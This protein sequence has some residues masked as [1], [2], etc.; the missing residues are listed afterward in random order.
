MKSSRGFTFIEVV[1]ALAVISILLP[2]VGIVFYN[3]IVTPPD[4]GVRLKL[5]NEIALLSSM[6]YQD[7]HLSNNFSEGTFPYYGNF[8]WTDYSV[9]PAQ[10]YLVSYYSTCPNA[11][12]TSCVNHIVRQVGYGNAST[13][14]IPT[15]TPTPTPV[16]TI[17][18]KIEAEAYDSMSGIATETTSDTGGGLNV[19]WT[20]PGD[21]MDYNV[22]VQTA[23]TYDITF[24]M[25]ADT[26]PPGKLELKEGGTLLCSVDTPVTG[27]WQTW[28]NVS[29]TAT[30][31]SGAKTLRISVVTAGWNL[32]WITFS[33]ATPTTQTYDYSA[34]YGV[35][36]W[37]WGRV[38]TN[39][40]WVTRPTNPD[41]F[42]EL[43]G[44]AAVEADTNMYSQLG[45]EDGNSWG[46]PNTSP[47]DYGVDS[48]LYTIQVNQ[49][50]S[51][52]TNLSVKWIGYG[53]NSTDSTKLKIW[54]CSG[55]GSWNTLLNV[56]GSGS[57][58]ITTHFFPNISS[59]LNYI[60]ATT[61]SV[62]LLASSEAVTPPAINYSDLTVYTDYIALTVIATGTAPTPTP[63]ATPK[64]SEVKTETLSTGTWTAPDGVT[65]IDQVLVVAGGGGGGGTAAVVSRT[66][67]GGGAGGL[68]YQTNFAIPD[69]YVV[70]FTTVGTTTWTVPAGVTSAEVLVVGGGGAGGGRHGGGGAGGGLVYNAA[71]AVTAGAGITVTVGAGGL[72][73]QVDANTQSVGGNGGNSVF[74]S[75][76]ALGGGG[77]GSYTAAVP[78]GGGS[79][80]GGGGGV[81]TAAGLANQGDSG[82]G[83]GF[84]S[85]GGTGG[86]TTGGGGGG[87]A[88]AVGSNAAGADTGG[89]GGSGKYIVSFSA[90][91]VSGYFA[92]GGGGGGNSGGGTGGAGGGGNGAQNDGTIGIPNTGGGGGGVRSLTTSKQ[93]KAGGSGIVIIR[94]TTKTLT[95]NVGSGGAGGSGDNAGTDGGYSQ[96][97]SITAT[98]GG[99]GGNTAGRPGGSGGGGGTRLSSNAGG[100]ASPSGQGNA[101]GNGVYTCCLIWNQGGG[102]G[103]GAGG[104]GANGGDYQIGGNGGAGTAN[105]ISGS[106]VTY[107]GGGGGGS[108]GTA[109]TGGSGGGG[110]GGDTAN[111]ANA[112][113]YGSGGGGGSNSAGT[114]TSRTGGAGSNGIVIIKYTIGYFTLTTSVNASGGGTVTPAPPGKGDCPAGA[115]Q[116][117]VATNDSCYYFVNW[118]GTGVDE[119]ADRNASSTTI[120]MTNNYTIQ[121]NFAH[122][123][124]NYSLSSPLTADPAAG[125]LPYFLG[126]SPFSCGFNVP[127]FA[128]P[129]PAYNF[130]GWTLSGSGLTT[131]IAN[132]SAAN[133]TV[134]MTADRSLT[135]HYGNLPVPTPS[136]TPATFNTT[137]YLTWYMTADN[138]SLK[139]YGT[140]IKAN[141]SSGVKTNN[142][143]YVEKQ[144]TIYITPRPSYL[145]PKENIWGE[146]PISTL[147]GFL[148]S[149][150]DTTISGDLTV[151]GTVIVAGTALRNMIDGTLT[152]PNISGNDL[153]KLSYNLPLINM[154]SKITM[155][156]ISLA[157]Y[158]ATNVSAVVLSGIPVLDDVLHEYVFPG[159]ISLTSE[160]RVWKNN[161]PSTHE[162]KP[163]TYYSPGTITLTD[164][165]TRGTVTFIA[166]KKIIITN[167]DTSS[168][169]DTSRKIALGPY[170]KDILF[171]A[172]GSTL[173]GD[174]LITGISTGHPCVTLE[175]VLF[176][177]NGEIKLAGS[178]MN[179]TFYIIRAELTNSALITKYLTISGS[180]W[181]IYRH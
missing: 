39:T 56:S 148:I 100:A 43:P 17:P 28:T 150:T 90:Y 157:D 147:S 20:D 67:G 47:E 26:T 181:N 84:G 134:L 87:G 172:N 83:T 127:I 23:G 13:V 156:N 3:L 117:I 129:D 123:T 45:N 132:P 24:R 133:T 59:P 124:S 126:S 146:N 60:D 2:V 116:S 6:L 89:N 164:S 155:P 139:K 121:A 93:G 151:N 31:S 30:L 55:S 21:W 27:G 69:T 105:S 38:W 19:G 173:D 174:I 14:P 85:N 18:G 25:A 94:Y 142:G 48:Q 53:G 91:G 88:G 118:S 169:Y 125:G 10:D 119:V 160:A 57:K 77:G 44:H 41:N 176:A 81:N 165:H 37:A 143:K 180:F 106:S 112:T 166:A 70:T 97:G 153:A 101:G 110:N 141:M 111:G 107:A 40:E 34:G 178:G 79:G 144:L 171:W 63:T 135:A 42:F 95:V 65:L 109:G 131:G 122:T 12:N 158:I 138:F 51:A 46:N 104:A 86:A 162:L 179:T 92:G 163:G 167:N 32:N 175:G 1:I 8:T 140:V 115:T 149:G 98:G 108:Q 137:M 99:G 49:N 96:F 128:N 152:C 120:H 66:G 5:N 68:R 82:G 22:N 102:G 29:A 76:T 72:P 170:N 71:Y 33:P 114:S 9:T 61:G 74:G 16:K 36:K 168:T 58:I 130:S 52:V 80:G 145:L 35:N 159:N 54:N 62:S 154:N 113:G 7:A 103:G 75:I 15:T 11:S 161:L 73:T 50:R 64:P 4:Q 177:P 136:P 78:T